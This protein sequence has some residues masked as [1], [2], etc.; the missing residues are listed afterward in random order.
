MNPYVS[1]REKSI[2]K[3]SYQKC[4]KNIFFFSG[5]ITLGLTHHQLY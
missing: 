5:S 4:Y 1:F 2:P 3:K